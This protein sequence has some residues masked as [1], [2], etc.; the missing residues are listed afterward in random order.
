VAGGDPVTVDVRRLGSKG[1]LAISGDPYL[2]STSCFALS[3][4]RSTGVYTVIS[5]VEGDAPSLVVGFLPDRARRAVI[6]VGD[7]PTL[8]KTRARIFLAE[9]GPGALGPNGDRPVDVEFD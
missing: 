6:T 1:C 9:L 2:T 4:A 8:G 5:P 3:S 7:A